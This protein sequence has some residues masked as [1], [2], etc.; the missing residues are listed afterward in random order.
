[1]DPA[2]WIGH[3]LEEL[4]RTGFGGFIGFSG[5]PVFDADEET[6]GYT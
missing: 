5:E 1:V 4:H 2:K 6:V 3:D